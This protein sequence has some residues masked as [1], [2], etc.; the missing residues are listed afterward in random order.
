LVRLEHREEAL[1]LGGGADRILDDARRRLAQPPLQV[2][3]PRQSARDRV[4][5]RRHAVAKKTRVPQPSGS[6]RRAPR[7][8]TNS[9]SR[10]APLL[11]SASSALRCA[12]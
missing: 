2:A 6:G 5:G 11:A 7:P 9:E 10:T 3:E 8:T 1:H 4:G 12:A